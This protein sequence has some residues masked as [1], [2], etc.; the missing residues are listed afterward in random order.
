MKSPETPDPKT[1]VEIEDVMLDALLI[2]VLSTQSPPDQS[3]AIIRRLTDQPTQPV[4]R[5]T[6]LNKKITSSK[7]A[8]ASRKNTI[9]FWIAPVLVAALLLVAVGVGFGIRYHNRANIAG[10]LPQ[11]NELLANSDGV[12]SALPKPD[13]APENEKRDPSSVRGA[14]TD[15]SLP[16][17]RIELADSESSEGLDRDERLGMFATDD[18]P[19]S[20]TPVAIAPPREMTLVSSSLTNHLQRYWDRVGLQPTEMLS[21][22]AIAER[23]EA[24][25]RIEVPVGAIGN[26]VEM[27]TAIGQPSNSQS[28][29]TRI[30]SA[31]S[32]RPVESLD[33]DVDKRMAVQINETLRAGSGFDR[34][35]ASWFVKPAN[36]SEKKSPESKTTTQTSSSIAEL[37]QPLG[38]HETLVTTASVALNADVRCQRCHDLKSGGSPNGQGLSQHDYWG[39][40]AT[41]APWLSIRP[42]ADAGWFY[43]TPDARRRLAQ[44]DSNA[45][46][47]ER[48]IGSRLLAEGLVASMWTMVHGRPLASS[49]YDLSGSAADSDLRQ[50]REELASDLVASDFNLL[51]TISL[52]LTDSTIGRSTPSSMSP[53]GMLT[54]TNEQWTAAVAAVESFAASPPASMPS[55]RGHRMR[56]VQQSELPSLLNRGIAAS[57]L[58]QPL[59]SE[60]VDSNS[61]SREKSRSSATAASQPSP[62]MLAGLPMRATLVLPAWI[63]ELPDFES[64]LTHI[65]HLAGLSGVPSQARELA[66][67]MK[68]AEVEEALILQRIWWIIRP[69]G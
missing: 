20:G 36:R 14:N 31:I 58:A 61:D 35:Y 6:P 25:F 65:A 27:M 56:L 49:P 44:A 34:L 16:S 39:F 33:R 40:A 13:V 10:T 4:I 19:R 43:D 38:E 28:L 41:V 22:D 52:M 32:S 37:L 53:A 51:R 12:S 68:D 3:R 23:L 50:L 47:P 46:W 30:L 69:Q 66:S 1:D 63:V 54:A 59:G 62:A 5:K 7:N 64:R 48:L 26:P 67:Q 60:S 55:T 29:A 42:N 9:P 18:P 15:G 21:T 8:L 2:E 24:R 57:V 11:P 17:R 45:N